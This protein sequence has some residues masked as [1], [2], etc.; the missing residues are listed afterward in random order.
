MTDV[1]LVGNDGVVFTFAEG[2]VE[3]VSSRMESGNEIQ[4]LFGQGPAGNFVFDS[5]GP[6]KVVS[7][8]GQLF[9]TVATRTSVGTTTSIL[10]QK[11]WLEK[12][13]NGNQAV[14]SFTSNYES[15]TWNG[16]EFVPTKVVV[17]LFEFNEESGRPSDAEF[18]IQFL[19]GG[20]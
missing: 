6:Q 15:E 8:R 1:T 7:I 10:Q 11:Q 20:S 4:R 13:I 12:Q 14:R 5:S 19:V 16:S 2:E 3:R 18:T 9:E 17:G